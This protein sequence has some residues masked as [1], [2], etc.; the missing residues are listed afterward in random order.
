MQFSFYFFFVHKLQ[1]PLLNVYNSFS[2]L[3]SQNDEWLKK[4]K[5]KKKKIIKT[6]NTNLYYIKITIKMLKLKKKNGFYDP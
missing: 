4:I 3:I 2:S 5:E 1:A 6:K